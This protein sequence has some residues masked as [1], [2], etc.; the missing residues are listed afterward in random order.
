MINSVCVELV[1]TKKSGLQEERGGKESCGENEQS[2][3]GSF[4]LLSCH[5]LLTHCA[6]KPC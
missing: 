6:P 2:K 3:E 1:G 4:L 5:H